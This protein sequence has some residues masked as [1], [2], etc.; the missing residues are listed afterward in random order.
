[1]SVARADRRNPAI[2]LSGVSVAL[3]ARRVVQDVNLEILGGELVVLL[4]PNGAGKTTLLRAIAGLALAEGQL[5]VFGCSVKKMPVRRRAT[6]IA[7]LPQNGEVSWPMSVAEVVSLGRL[8]FGSWRRRSFD[9]A[10]DTVAQAI[11]DCDLSA[12]ATRSIEELSGGER[13]RVLL[14]RMLSVNAPIILA[15]EPVASLD[16][17]HQINTMRILAREAA[18]GRAVI[19][20]MHDVALAMRYATRAIGLQEGRIVAD[21]TPDSFLR[22]GVMDRLYGIGYEMAKLTSGALTP[23]ARI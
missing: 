8:P 23:V 19:A 10:D 14:A 3:G 13:A 4:G 21:A 15:D 6:E 7:Y 18:K 20:V 1:M 11:H 9:D 17:A 2:S 16:P 22:S 12:L 5:D